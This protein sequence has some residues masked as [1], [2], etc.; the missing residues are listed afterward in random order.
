MVHLRSR[1]CAQDSGWPDLVRTNVSDATKWTF[2]LRREVMNI[3]T[4]HDEAYFDH[5]VFWLFLDSLLSGFC[6]SAFCGYFSFVSWVPGSS[7]NVQHGT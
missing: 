1:V 6:L 5:G 3:R 7:I 2:P 4:C